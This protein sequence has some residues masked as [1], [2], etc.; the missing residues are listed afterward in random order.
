MRGYGKNEDISLRVVSLAPAHFKNT[1][2]SQE[3]C[4]RKIKG[5]KT[6]RVGGEESREKIHWIEVSTL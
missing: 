6:V 5:R 3:F 4:L 1:N 2:F